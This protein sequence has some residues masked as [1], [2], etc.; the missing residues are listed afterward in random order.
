MWCYDDRAVTHPQRSW[1][2][3]KTVNPAAYQ[4]RRLD[5]SALDTSKMSDLWN[6]I[7]LMGLQNRSITWSE[8]GPYGKRANVV[9][10]YLHLFLNNFSSGEYHLDL[11]TVVDRT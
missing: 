3:V 8:S 5:H 7:M 9:I 10:S 6:I 4:L 11:T 2:V 1:T